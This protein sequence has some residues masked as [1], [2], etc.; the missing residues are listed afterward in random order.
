MRQ[1]FIIGNWKMH[2]TS[3]ETKAFVEGIAPFIGES[4]CF[5]GITPSFTSIHAAAEAS[6]KSYLN[7]G[8]Q[9]MSEHSAGA[10]TGEV[11]SKMLK[12]AGAT[13]VLIGHS[14][15]R[16]LFHEDDQMIHRKLKWAIK[17]ELLPLLCI[18][19][20]QEERDNHQTE[21]VL[22]SQLQEALKDFS[23]TELENIVIAYEPVWAI[24]TGKTATP[25]IAQET[26]HLI[27]SYIAKTWGEELSTRLPL[28]YG[29]SVKAENAKVLLEQKDIDGA[30][31]GGASL[32]VETFRQIIEYG[33]DLSL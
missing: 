22:T 3:S 20:T 17:E 27:R 16:A 33:K 11:S 15:R 2:M 19:E 32:E 5:I 10:F 14:E 26:H 13:F 8:A 29:G 1:K 25:E 28:L 18:G 7:I 24:G 21:K 12:E 30:L 4:T 9:N 31:V 23:S 6:D